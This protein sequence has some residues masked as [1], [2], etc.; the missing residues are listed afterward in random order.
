MIVMRSLLVS[1]LMVSSAH[2]VDYTINLP[3][4]IVTVSD[5]LLPISAR[6]E[7]FCPPSSPAC[8]QS[9]RVAE[10]YKK[11]PIVEGAY[12]GTVTFVFNLTD[13]QAML[14][15]SYSCDFFSGAKGA[16]VKPTQVK[17]NSGSVLRVQGPMR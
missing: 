5:D 7:L 1:A 2:A 14:P 3:V 6:C 17:P 9:S 12:S 15:L 13:Q 11:L 8:A 16:D 10:Q 4:K